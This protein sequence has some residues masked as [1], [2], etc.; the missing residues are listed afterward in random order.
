MN[1]KKKGNQF[2]IKALQSY[3]NVEIVVTDILGN[4]IYSE[5]INNVNS[6]FEKQINFAK[7]LESGV[8]FVNFIRN[9]HFFVQMTHHK[10]T[11]WV[12]S[13]SKTKTFQNQ[14]LEINYT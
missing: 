11:S 6:G 14:K 7:K 3:Q 12:I 2:V 8:Y 13:L 5:V 10:N 4:K 1:I 9:I